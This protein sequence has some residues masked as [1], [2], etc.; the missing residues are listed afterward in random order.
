M[1]APETTRSAAPTWDRDDPRY[2]RAAGAWVGAAAAACIVGA[3]PAMAEE[4][5]EPAGSD[6]AAAR[7]GRVLAAALRDLDG[8]RADGGTGHGHP[9]GAPGSGTSG[10]SGNGATGRAWAAAL[11]RTVATGTVTAVDGAVPAESPMGAAWRAVVSTPVPG[12]D[13]AGRVFPCSQLVEAV[14]N[15]SAAGGDAAA[16]CA[17]AL[18][19]ARWGVSGV[20]LEAQRRLAD[21]VSPRALVTRGVVLARGSDPATWPEGEAYH[22][23]ASVYI[24]TD[25]H[26]PHPYDPGVVLGNLAHLRT[27]GDVDAV[28]S[29]N[30]ISPTDAPARI[31]ARDRV[32][33]WLHDREQ[34]NPNLH[35]VLDEA[36]GAV[37]ALRA[38]GKRVLLHCAA[39]Q[40]RTPAVAAHYA[41]QACGVPVVEALRRIVRAV[42]GHLKT[43][44]LAQATAALNGVH[45]PDPLHDI[46]PEGPPP[47]RPLP[48]P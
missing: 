42:G 9:T 15:A 12:L 39:G 16:M 28:V 36:A 40:S 44:E 25:F 4:L 3:P 33:V 26:T 45:L 10:A 13:P 22:T 24:R 38:E 11:R 27:G 31:P 14:W 48:P 29:L 34:V 43:P 23:G 20:P 46:F 2:D 17:G 30:R 5:A 19:G 8:P 18:A 41:A 7:L 35:F 32:E 37:A 6:T 21:T 47:L 1:N